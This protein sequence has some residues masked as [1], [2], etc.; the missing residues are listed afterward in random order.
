VVL[1]AELS[2]GALRK[3]G[4]IVGD[5]AVWEAITVDELTDELGGGFPVALCDGLGL[6]PLSE[7]VDCNEQVSVASLGFLELSHHVE[8]LDCK[9]PGDGD[10]LQC[11]TGEVH[12]VSVLLAPDAALDD[13]NC[14]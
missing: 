12:L 8:S 14:V 2:H 7:L 3:I 6:D 13:V 9:W 11:R 1:L 5:D 4:A 10:R